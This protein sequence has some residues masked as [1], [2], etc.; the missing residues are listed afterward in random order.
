QKICNKLCRLVEDH[1]FAHVK[2]ITCSIG[3]TLV[4]EDEMLKEA[5]E[6]A[7]NALYCS[8]NSGRNQVTL[9]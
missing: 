5:V 4:K 8:K 2:Q 7:D 1:T 3:A 9:L 6:R